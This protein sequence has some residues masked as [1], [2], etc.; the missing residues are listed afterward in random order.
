[1]EQ[2]DS[3]TRLV[4][5]FRR[6]PGIGRK[7][8]ERLAFHVLRMPLSEVEALSQDMYNARKNI[9]RCNVCG[10]LTES[11]TC[12]ICAD[13][14]RDHATICVVKDV[15]DVQAIEKTGEYRGVYHVLGGSIAP[16]EGVFPEDIN[17]PSLLER[18]DDTVEEVIL[19]TSTDVAGQATAA[20]LQEVLRP[21][22][23]RVSRIAYGIPVGTSLQYADEVTLTRALQGRSEMN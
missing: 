19:A 21:R 8:A 13:S 17:I 5:G 9:R 15:Q 10:N 23:V 14:H 6:L 7:S 22:G 3:F 18:V 11:E 12:S 1:M 4:E 2:S 16:A 20:Y